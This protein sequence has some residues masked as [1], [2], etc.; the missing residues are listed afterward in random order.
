M[1]GKK[2]AS[3][4]SALPPSE[5]ASL[6]REITTQVGEMLE[7]KLAKFSQTLD[8]VTTRL[9]KIDRR[10]A[11]AEQ[12]ISTNEDE[13]TALKLSLAEAKKSISTL[14]QK[15]D[16]QE[17]RSR[18]DNIRIIGLKEGIEGRE[19]VAFFQTWL[20]TVLGLDTKH[21]TVKLDRAHRTPGTPRDDNK[22]RSVI[23]KLHNYADKVRILAAFKTKQSVAHDGEPVY[24]RS[25]L[26]AG[27]V[28]QRR[29]FNGVCD[30]L[31]KRSIRFRMNFPATLVFSHGGEKHTFTNAKEAQALLD[32]GGL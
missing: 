26:S 2:D 29:A 19:P 16:E 8:N 31:I 24:I 1:T 22:P 32:R 11:E 27:V 21:G 23:M 30:L 7:I 15:T 9:E 18:R 4:T 6:I 12:R 13:I 17:N 5:H 28:E 10:F 14:L 20:P 25:D 3:R